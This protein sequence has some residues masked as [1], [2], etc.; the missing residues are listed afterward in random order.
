MVREECRRC[1]RL[2]S[3]AIMEAE[4]FQGDPGSLQASLYDWPG[5]EPSEVCRI[6][7][8]SAGSGEDNV[9][10]RYL[11]HLPDGQVSSWLASG[12]NP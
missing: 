12:S 6:T 4:K 7:H 9:V 2:Q 3:S 8:L 1:A 5:A 11:V 10:R